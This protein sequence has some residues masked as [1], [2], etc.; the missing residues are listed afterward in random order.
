MHK[1]LHFFISLPKKKGSHHEIYSRGYTKK[2]QPKCFNFAQ[3]YDIPG[4]ELDTDLVEWLSLR[5]KTL[6]DIYLSTK[7]LDIQAVTHA[8]AK[9]GHVD[10]VLSKDVGDG[11]QQNGIS[12]KLSDHEVRS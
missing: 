6:K 5:G 11:N 2:T 7:R 10:G 4:C 12:V 8:D 1:T 3:D 9:E